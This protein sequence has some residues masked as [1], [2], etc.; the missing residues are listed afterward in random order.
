MDNRVHHPRCVEWRQA[1]HPVRE[2][3]EQAP[4]IQ[5]DLRKEPGPE[6]REKSAQANQAAE[7]RGRCTQT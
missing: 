7:Y 5:A 1:S 3:L 2:S 6:S 4:D